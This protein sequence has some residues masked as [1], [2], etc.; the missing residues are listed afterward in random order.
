[1]KGF[2][3]ITLGYLFSNENIEEGILL[4]YPERGR[5]DIH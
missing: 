5:F 1:M 2:A 3:S 4:A